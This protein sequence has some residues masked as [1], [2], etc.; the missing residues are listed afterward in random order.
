MRRLLLVLAALLLTLGAC[1]QLPICAYD[2][3][4]GCVICESTP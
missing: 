2:C 1:G 4:G 3:A